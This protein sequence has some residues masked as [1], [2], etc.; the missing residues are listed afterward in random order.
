[1]PKDYPLASLT[2]SYDMV[3]EQ[4]ISYLMET[5]RKGID[6]SFFNN[7]LNKIPF[8]LTE[9]SAFLHLS[10]R[11]MQ[12]YKKEK[13]TF[14]TLQSEKIL[15]ITLLYKKGIDVFGSP[16]KFNSWLDTKN[17]SLGKITPK[18]LLD[19]AFGIDM[20]E[21]ELSRIEFGILA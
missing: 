7:I 2:P 8:S 5:V 11:T 21:D 4:D 13:K 10:E 9:W 3:S 15:Q 20:L 18:S 12:R 14:D 17:I 16:E 1:M 19:N 6:F